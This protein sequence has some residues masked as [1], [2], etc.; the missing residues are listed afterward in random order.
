MSLEAFGDESPG[1]D[2]DELYSHGWASDPDCEVFWRVGY[3]DE[4]C[5]IQEAY[6]AHRALMEDTE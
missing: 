1:I 6:E 4:T 3:E 5:T 2:V